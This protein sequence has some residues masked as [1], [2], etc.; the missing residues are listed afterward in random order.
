MA[1]TNPI[2][3]V[4]T[5]FGRVQPLSPNQ[6]KHGWAGRGCHIWLQW[7]RSGCQQ[8]LI[9]TKKKE[10]KRKT[11]GCRLEEEG[12]EKGGGGGF[13][14][15]YMVDFIWAVCVCVCVQLGCVC[16]SNWP[17]PIPNFIM[18]WGLPQSSR[19]QLRREQTNYCHWHLWE[20]RGGVGGEDFSWRG[21]DWTISG[22]VGQLPESEARSAN[23]VMSGR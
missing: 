20:E 7:A 12:E 22:W 19:W 1:A 8:Q 3:P 14:F 16:V 4:I 11:S 17:F 9:W 13:N 2:R 23:Q 18:P 15:F 10:K 21:G 6:A 5:R